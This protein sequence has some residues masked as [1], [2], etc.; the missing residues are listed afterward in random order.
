MRSQRGGTTVV[1]RITMHCCRKDMPFR[2]HTY[3]NRSTHRS[4]QE[5][6]RERKSGERQEL[7]REGW[8]GGTCRT[9]T[10]GESYFQTK[11]IVASWRTCNE[12]EARARQAKEECSSTEKDYKAVWRPHGR[13][14]IPNNKVVFRAGEE[15]FRFVR[16]FGVTEI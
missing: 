10:H 4:S 12:R 14:C 8:G 3:V 7:E 13:M 9:G 5:R 16:L 1:Q 6:E 11:T 15:R 2:C